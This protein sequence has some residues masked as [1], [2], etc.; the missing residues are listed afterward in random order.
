MKTGAAKALG[1]LIA[2]T[3]RTQEA[4]TAALHFYDCLKICFTYG[5][6]S[7]TIMFDAPQCPECKKFYNPD[8]GC[9]YENCGSKGEENRRVD[10]PF[11]ENEERQKILNGEYPSRIVQGRQ[12]KHIPDTKEFE[13]KRESMQREDPYNEPAIVEVDAQ[14]LVDK[15]KGTGV[16]RKDSGSLFPR[17]TV[18]VDFVV[19]KTWV[20]SLRKYVDTDTFTILYSNKGTHIF[21]R[22]MYSSRR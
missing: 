22:N 2:H 11:N 13:Q 19:G 17:E 14:M 9:K 4:V 5:H 3:D 12:N 20:K 18:T 16:I 1:R 15:Y 8:K 6:G 10:A 21:P 7:G